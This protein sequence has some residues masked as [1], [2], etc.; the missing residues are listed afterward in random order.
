M[1]TNSLAWPS[2][3]SMKRMS[4]NFWP[5]AFCA[6]LGRSG[7][8]SA[9]ATQLCRG[10]WTSYPYKIPVCVS[11]SHRER[12]CLP[13]PAKPWPA[14]RFPSCDD[15]PARKDDCELSRSGLPVTLI[16][17]R[18]R[19]SCLRMAPYQICPLNQMNQG[20]AYVPASDIGL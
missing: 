5:R 2:S 17:D 9:R 6:G 3:V 10:T 20:N 18:A 7:E 15:S 19:E 1:A 16:R 11:D 12:V 4:N 8:R 14:S 13:A